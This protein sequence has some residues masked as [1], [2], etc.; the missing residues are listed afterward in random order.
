MHTRAIQPIIRQIIAMLAMLALRIGIQHR[1]HRGFRLRRQ[2]RIEPRIEPPH[3]ADRVAHLRVILNI[4]DRIP[5]MLLP[6]GQHPFDHQVEGAQLRLADLDRIDIVAEHLAHLIN[7]AARRRDDIGGIAMRHHQLRV[8]INGRQIIQKQR[9]PRIFQRPL[10]ALILLQ[11]LEQPLLIAEGRQVA[12]GKQPLLIA[13]NIEHR[14]II[15]CAEGR[16]HRELALG[17][18][19]RIL[20]MHR[21]DMRRIFEHH[22]EP[23]LFR[24]IARIAAQC[25]LGGRRH[26]VEGFPAQE[27]PPRRIGIEQIDRQRRARA[28]QA[29]NEQR[30]VD[31][32]IQ[33]RRMLR[34]II[35]DLQPVRQRG[36]DLLRPAPLR[37]LGQLRLAIDRIDQDVQPFQ[38]RRIAQIGQPRLIAR[39]SNKR[40]S[41]QPSGGGRHH[42]S[43]FSVWLARRLSVSAISAFSH[44]VSDRLLLPLA[45]SNCASAALRTLNPAS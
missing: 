33:Q 36:G 24:H 41:V 4:V 32:R 5:A 23:R 21:R 3:L 11:H 15:L 18:A 43:P 27:A 42:P 1:L 31:R 20:M 6:I 34:Q 9:M 16:C 8:G 19:V 38:H 37:R 25:T 45:A 14:V 17:R 2:R 13:R 12:R 26:A 35:L 7:E 28:R 10:P 22:V 40:V 39:R 29:E 44:M 30:L